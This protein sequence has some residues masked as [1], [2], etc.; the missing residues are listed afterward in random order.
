[1]VRTYQSELVVD[2]RNTLGESCFWDPRD[3]SLY[4]TDIE[5]RTIYRRH[6]AKRIESFSLPERAG[7]ILPRRQPGFV[8]GFPKRIVVAPPSLDSFETV[9]DVETSE[10]WLRINDAAVDPFGGI[11]FG[12]YNEDPQQKPRP[13][14]AGFHRVGPDGQLQTLLSGF[15]TC[16]GIAF[17]KD[18]A[19]MYLT[20]S[21]EGTIR[22]FSF[23]QDFQTLTELPPLASPRVAPGKPDGSKID[24]SDGCW[25]ARVWGNCVV[26]IAPS[27]DVTA[28]VEV[29]CKGPT[30][31][32]FGGPERNE[33]YITT[34]RKNH[35]AAELASYPQVGGLFCARVD[36]AGRDQLLSHL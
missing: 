34:L 32:A 5:E 24:C 36:V 18:A 9:C 21:A 8:L 6:S 16:N 15:R 13:A 19:T 2:C 22:K 11:V 7:F 27:G 1:M 35:T 3:E 4:W 30:C 26:C 25:N 33:L 12:S 14:I 31:V 17:C 20:D 10:R 28:R 29:P 23:D